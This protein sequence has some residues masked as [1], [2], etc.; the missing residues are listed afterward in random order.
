MNDGN[1]AEEMLQPSMLGEHGSIRGS[2]ILLL[3]LSPIRWG[4][5]HPAHHDGFP[6]PVT[7]GLSRP[8]EISEMG[9]YFKSKL[10][11]WPT[12]CVIPDGDHYS[13]P[14][15]L[16]L[17]EHPFLLLCENAEHQGS[18]TGERKPLPS[19][20]SY[21]SCCSETGLSHN[22]Y[23]APGLGWGV[24]GQVPCK[25]QSN[26]SPVIPTDLQRLVLSQNPGIIKISATL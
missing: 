26:R 10:A 6:Q 13:I 16:V 23:R 22:I 2:Q 3:F 8:G 20:Y 18:C 12:H 11:F 24:G 4:E 5:K 14:S 19:H 9:S 15:A 7:S 17:L 21:S 25:P 1:S